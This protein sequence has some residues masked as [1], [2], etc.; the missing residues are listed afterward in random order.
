MKRTVLELAF[1]ALMTAILFVQQ[2]ALSF[3]PNVHLCAVLIL[4]YAASFP[5]L[6]PLILPGFLLLEGIFYG[7]GLW[8][9]SYLYIWPLV[10]IIGL[11][12][13]RRERPVPVWAAV[14]GA[15]G[16]SFGFLCAL[17]YFLA[18]GPAA[19]FSYWVAGIPFDLVHCVSNTVLT[20]ALWRPLRRL[21]DR[22]NARL[23]RG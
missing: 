6:V 8:W 23:G 22:L 2:V 5:R 1:A 19:G 20:L 16:L 4:W 14:A 21:S 10:A 11:L 12:L 9:F 3:L 15:F 7:F 17:P 18:G 13:R